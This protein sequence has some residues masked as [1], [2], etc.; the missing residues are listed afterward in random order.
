MAKSRFTP[1]VDAVLYPRHIPELGLLAAVLE[2]AFRDL[3]PEAPKDCRK[4]AITWFRGKNLEPVFPEFTFNEVSKYL[5][6]S[7]SQIDYIYKKVNKAEDVRRQRLQRG[8]LDR[9]RARDVVQRLVLAGQVEVEHGRSVRE[10][11]RLQ[12][13]SRRAAGDGV[14]QQPRRA[15]TQCPAAAAMADV[16]P[17]TAPRRSAPSIG[18][19]VGEHRARALPVRVALRRVTAGKPVVEH[20][21]S[22]ACAR[23][24]WRLEVAADLGAA[25]DADA[26]AEAAD[27]DLVALVHQ[28]RAAARGAGER[29]RRAAAP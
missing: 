25:G 1:D 19:P 24:L 4:S 27:R 17:D 22:V 9:A 15:A 13:C 21:S 3:N 28:R 6:L 5:G 8:V 2:M 20:R 11:E 14:G 18:G 12:R 7:L 10:R 23:S 29:R 26:L 16:E